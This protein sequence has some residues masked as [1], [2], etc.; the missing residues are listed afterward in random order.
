YFYVYR[1]RGLDEMLPWDFID[2]GIDKAFLATEYKQA[3]EGRVSPPC[4]MVPCN[5]CSVC[6]GGGA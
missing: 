4:P 3:M 6:G 1:D 2:H 5:I